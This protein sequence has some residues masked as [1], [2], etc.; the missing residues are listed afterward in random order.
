[1]IKWTTFIKN[2]TIESFDLKYSDRDS[3]DLDTM[4]DD[5]DGQDTHHQSQS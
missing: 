1:M 5:E 3:D 2:R 4:E